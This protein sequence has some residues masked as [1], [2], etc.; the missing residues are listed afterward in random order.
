MF[1]KI[2]DESE[3]ITGL[4]RKKC[5]ENNFVLSKD[6]GRFQTTDLGHVEGWETKRCVSCAAS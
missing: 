4:I 5:S 2:K 6:A 3:G 1:C